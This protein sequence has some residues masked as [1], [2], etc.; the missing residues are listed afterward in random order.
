MHLTLYFAALALRYY[1]TDHQERDTKLA[2]DAD[3]LCPA[4]I[5]RLGLMHA[6]EFGSNA[7]FLTDLYLLVKI[8]QKKPKI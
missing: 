6:C 4:N 1:F 7:D 2:V 8:N 3:S 5:D